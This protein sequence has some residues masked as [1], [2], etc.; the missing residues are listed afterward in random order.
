[1]QGLILAAGMGS[2]L[3]KLTQNNTKGMV[4]VNGISLME[5]MARQIEKSGCQKLIVVTGYE[6]QKLQN[7]IN[8]LNLS[9]EVEYV[10]ND[11]YDKTN[12]IYSLY[13]AKEVMS[14]D[15]TI[16]LESDL[17]F[18]DHVLTNLMNDPRSTLSLVDQYQPWMDGTCVK[19]ND[20]DEIID[21][22]PGKEFKFSDANHYFKTVN[23]YKFSKQF[24]SDVYF[25]A[26]E[27]YMQQYGRN[28]YYEAVLSL[29]L[30]NDPTAIL[31]KR[32]E[33]EKW[34]EIDDQQDLDIASSMFCDKK[35]KLVKFQKRFGGYWRYPNL[36]DYCYLVN[37]YFPPQKMV[38]ELKYSF[39]E[40][41]QQYPS[42]QSVNSM[43]A[44]KYFDVSEPYIVIGNGAA[45]LI[46][47]VM[48]NIE[49]NVGFI[50]PTFEE[51]P[52]RYDKQHSIVYVPENDN[53]SYDDHDII[54]YFSDKQLSALVLI[55]PDNPSGNYIGKDGV[56]RLI[57]WAKQNQIIFILDESFVDFAMEDDPTFIK[58]DILE[59]YDQLVV[60]K[61]ISKSYG[62]PGCRLGVLATSNRELI[63]FI[64]KDV[65][66]W[67]INSFGEYYLQ[68]FGKYQ[69]L[70][71]EA[72][73]KI[74]AERTRFESLLSQVKE[75]RVIPSQANYLMI[76]VL[77]GTSLELCEDLLADYELFI[78]DLSPKIHL[79]NRQFIRIAIRD[80][81]DND[82]FMQAILNYY[83]YC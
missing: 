49:G 12:N 19:L 60:V 28:Q 23:I 57:E 35:E 82:R 75:F 39:L 63:Q 41:L 8:Q 7:H 33:S 83:H 5:R 74:K 32:V 44:A 70:Y 14:Q 68:I 20:H 76:E 69:K 36:L 17:I 46:K 51:Y 78:K 71:G 26:L 10:H 56:M 66:I 21:F 3:R 6:G 67:N 47:S 42:G 48:T 11:I 1:M 18:D 79:D 72:L 59:L 29:V 37:P 27:K 65:S 45:E 80:Q 22:I 30:K 15:D 55:N 34:Y 64:R 73:D 24:S 50:R 81:K 43:L 38:D 9:I 2:R 77:K 25:P 13:L 4:E 54:H 58:D 62:V 31:A 40:L 52:N 61:S 16:L 53:F